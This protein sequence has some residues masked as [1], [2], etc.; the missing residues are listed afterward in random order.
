[1][2]ARG[3]DGIRRNAYWVEGKAERRRIGTP[4]CCTENNTEMDLDTQ[5]HRRRWT[6]FSEST[7]TGVVC[8]DLLEKFVFP[9]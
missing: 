7:I 1:M 4:T 3:R 5:G 2:V 9:D 8:L 6:G